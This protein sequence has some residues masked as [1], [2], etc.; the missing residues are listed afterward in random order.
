MAKQLQG[1]ETP[2]VDTNYNKNFTN[3]IITL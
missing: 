2:I 3:T 1:H